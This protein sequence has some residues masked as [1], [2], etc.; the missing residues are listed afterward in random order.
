MIA[1][2]KPGRRAPSVYEVDFSK[3]YADGVRG[4]ILD[5]DNTL[6][7]QD[8]PADERAAKLI[9]DLKEQGFRICLISNNGLQRVKSFADAVGAD[10]YVEH[11]KKPSRKAYLRALQALSADREKT[12]FIGDQLFTDIWGANRAGLRH[13]LVDPVDPHSDTVP[14]RL[15]RLLEKPF[16]RQ[17]TAEVK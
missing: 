5:I 1:H 10:F 7:A 12:L 15:K 11:A 9:R 17:N 16:L 8:A 4:L 14:I 6:V 13:I 2:L 3:E